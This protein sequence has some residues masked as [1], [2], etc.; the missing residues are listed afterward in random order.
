MTENINERIQEKQA[1]HLMGDE[2]L[3]V[4][5]VTL[6][7][8]SLASYKQKPEDLP[9]TD[10]V[11]GEFRKHPDVFTSDQDIQ[12]SAQTIVGNLTLYNDNRTELQKAIAA[13][14]TAESWVVKKIE[15]GAKAANAVNIGQYA[16]DIDKALQSANQQ[17]MDTF[18][19]LDGSINANKNLHG[20]V[21][22]N[23]H[24][25]SFN[26]DA[27]TSG[28]QYRAQ[29]LQSTGKN[30]VDI[31]IKDMDRGKI[32]KRYGAKYGQTAQDS[33]KYF[34]KGDYRGQRKLVAD[35]QELELDNT[36]NKIEMEG[37]QSEPLSYQDA[38]ERQ[39]EIQEQQAIQ[40]VNWDKLNKVKFAKNIVQETGKMVVLQ[41]VFQGGRILGKRIYN[42]ATGKANNT[43]NED[44][45]A[46]FDSSKQGAKSVA[47]QSVVTTGVTIAVRKG[48][49]GALAKSTPVGKIAEV[50]YVGIENAKVVY[51][52]AKGE[53]GIKEGLW[54]MQETTLSTVGG[55]VGATEGAAIGAALGSVVPVVGTVIG[56]AIG[57]IVGGMAGS[58]VGEL[59]AEGSRKV[60]QASTS[61]VK[62][63][64]EKTRSVAK[65]L[66]N[67]MTLGVFA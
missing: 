58:T 17:S 13:G 26:L 59:V 11:E 40:E 1:S 22:E 12:Q 52:M 6:I 43:A 30:S 19:N 8:D 4:G 35:G 25:N 42:S 36:T 57:A 44:L 16:H 51:K 2:Q 3:N 23:A 37:I 55:L 65:G 7:Q 38:K 41:S 34:A 56:G 33:E 63:A 48:L 61:L 49:L 15:A 29:M 60:Y 47:I 18:I 20:F 54:K 10:W 27:A 28:S 21:A 32:V 31:V 67:V 24:V 66:F 39:R 5:V 53:I 9:L 45:K 14:K 50:V 64:Y 46:W 62:K